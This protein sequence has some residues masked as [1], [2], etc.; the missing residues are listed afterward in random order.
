MKQVLK[1]F[2]DSLL[3]AEK[4]VNEYRREEQWQ[5]LRT[6]ALLAIAAFL[7]MAAANVYQHSW[8][9]LAS[10]L[11]GALLLFLA[12]LVSKKGKRTFWVDLAFFVDLLVLFTGYLI[13]GGNDGFALLW[14]VFI[15]FLY[16][17]MVNVRMGLLLTIYYLLLLFLTFYGPLESILRYDYPPMM[18]L[19]FPLLYLIDCVLSLY[20]VRKMIM[21]RSELIETQEKLKIVSFVDVNTGLQNRAAYSHYQQNACFDGMGQL[22]VVFID[23]NG[24]HELNNRLG[25]QAGDEMLRYVGQ[26]CVEMFP[27][28]KVYRL[29]GDEFLLIIERKEQCIVQSTMEALDEKVQEAGYSIAYGIEFRRSCFDLESMVNAADNKML[30]AKAEHYKKFDRRRR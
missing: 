21:D 14:I 7:V 12:L 18:R 13:Y 15:P 28:D 16:M 20:C 9:M 22:A 30:G 8:A 19:R 5:Q 26:L 10:T 3:Q 25:H 17:T 11:G 6:I 2:F 23:V 24:L 4:R 1:N 27:E 29:G